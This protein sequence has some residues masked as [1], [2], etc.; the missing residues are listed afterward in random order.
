MIR[1]QVWLSGSQQQIS[2]ASG[3]RKARV[4]YVWCSLFCS[5]VLKLQRMYR[6]LTIDQYMKL[7]SAWVC[8]V[9]ECANAV[10]GRDSSRGSDSTF[11]QIEEENRE[12]CDVCSLGWPRCYWPIGIQQCRTSLTCGFMLGVA[13]N[14]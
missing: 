10:T 7:R 8:I 13:P 5:S 12:G 9:V 2:S 3:R 4:V 1:S 11:L 6:R 14:S